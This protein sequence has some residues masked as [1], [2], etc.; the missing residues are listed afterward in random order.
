L[1]VGQRPGVYRE[2]GGVHDLDAGV[3]LA[4]ERGDDRRGRAR[5]REIDVTL[6]S[7]STL[8]SIPV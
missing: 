1:H 4:V 2:L 8:V 6:V 7:G 5:L 3:L